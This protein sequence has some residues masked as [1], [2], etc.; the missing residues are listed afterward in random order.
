MY[1]NSSVY[2]GLESWLS[3][4]YSKKVAYLMSDIK[5]SGL[6]FNRNLFNLVID[7]CKETYPNFSW[8]MYYNY[9]N[10][11]IIIDDSDPVPMKNGFGLGMMDCVISFTQ[12]CI[13]QLVMSKSLVEGISLDA[14]FWSDDMVIKVRHN[15]DLE[16]SLDCANDIL[17]EYDRYAALCGLRIHE[18]KPYASRKGVFLETYG[19][20]YYAP[21]DH[22]KKCQWTGCLFDSLKSRTI[23]Q[24]KHIFA[25]VSLE[26]PEELDYLLHEALQRITAFWGFE[27]SKHETTYPY[28]IGGWMYYMEEGFNMLFHWLDDQVESTDLLKCLNVSLKSRHFKYPLLKFHKDNKD[29]IDAIISK[30]WLDDPSSL[31]WDK[32]ARTSLTTFYKGRKAAVSY[33]HKYQ[34]KRE[35]IWKEN[36]KDLTILGSMFDMWDQVK[37]V[38]WF[39]PPLFTIDRKFDVNLLPTPKIVKDYVPHEIDCLRC[40]LNFTNI[41]G[42]EISVSDPNVKY[43]D[44]S[45]EDLIAMYLWDKSKGK[46]LSTAN[47]AFCISNGYDYE[48][49]NSRIQSKFGDFVFKKTA[50]LQDVIQFMEEISGFKGEYIFPLGSIKRAVMTDF[51]NIVTTPGQVGYEESLAIIGG[52]DKL[53]ASGNIGFE[54]SHHI[55]SIIKDARA[56]TFPNKIVPAEPLPDVTSTYGGSEALQKYMASVVSVF[57]FGHRENQKI[58]PE[59]YSF[60]P[61]ASGGGDYSSS[62]LFDEEDY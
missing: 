35:D 45:P 14:K 46:L 60:D 37:S 49:V 18:K 51:D 47:V 22:S 5:K 17:E 19:T 61:L 10:A 33:E 43:S 41:K 29:Y 28:E 20:S 31:S 48:R 13:Y 15:S 58:E 36:P 53:K 54:I 55:D 2:D 39:L 16:I 56:V 9:G 11:K 42:A 21:W 27:F 23:S 38:G 25:T 8:D 26:V 62:G 50:D 4:R 7:C 32:I 59:D 40:W 44:H 24:A 30:G 3:S 6:T 34:K 52:S 57:S 1:T 12:A